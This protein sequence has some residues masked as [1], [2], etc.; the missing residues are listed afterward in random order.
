M[1]VAVSKQDKARGLDARRH[2][3]PVGRDLGASG[4]CVA[5]AWPV[6]WPA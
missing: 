5:R 3:L 2:L 1:A 6:D 4:P